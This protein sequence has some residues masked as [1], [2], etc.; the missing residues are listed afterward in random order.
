MFAFSAACGPQGPTLLYGA[1]AGNTYYLRESETEAAA[2]GVHVEVSYGMW[3]SRGSESWAPLVVMGFENRGEE[4]VC[5]SAYI[6]VT[7]G[8]YSDI[9]GNGLVYRLEPGQSRP[10]LAG[11][12]GG[13]PF[14]FA[15]KVIVKE[16]T[17][18]RC[19]VFP[20]VREAF[21][22]S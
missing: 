7:E 1:F 13:E 6:D 14:L 3:K 12:A 5:T 11:I 19:P 10:Q 17:N 9:W 8:Y 16:L 2:H 20:T 15:Y 21:G 4:P 22:R 18:D